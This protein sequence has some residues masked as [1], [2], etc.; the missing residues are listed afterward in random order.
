MNLTIVILII[1]IILIIIFNCQSITENFTD[2]QNV[3][4]NAIKKI[5][6]FN[7][8]ISPEKEVMDYKIKKKASL[9]DITW[10]RP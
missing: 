7:S 2:G 8:P 1:I 9:W 4:I 5:K 10:V 6:V 3:N